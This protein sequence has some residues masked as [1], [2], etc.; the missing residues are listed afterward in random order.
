MLGIM[1]GVKCK[2]LEV[3]FVSVVENKIIRRENKKIGFGWRTLQKT[4]SAKILYAGR[5]KNY[6]LIKS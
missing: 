5:T 3:F 6:A 4:T 2:G 1:K